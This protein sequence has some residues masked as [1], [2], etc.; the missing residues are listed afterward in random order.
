MR[1]RLN[2]NKMEYITFGSRAHIHKTS[3][4]PLTTS[5]DIIQ[6][7]PHVKYLRG[8]L[9]SELNFNK[10]ITMTLQ[11]AMS[12]FTCRKAIQKYLTKQACVTLVPSLCIMHLDYSNALLYGLPKIHKE[13]KNSS[14]HICQ[15]CTATL[16][17][18]Q[19]NTSTHG[20]SLA[21][22]WTMNPLQYY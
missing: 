4:I 17:V 9:D 12:N 22:N 6:M 11:K 14:K 2:T 5:N 20:P 21:H 10:D 15:A 1:V 19:C 18:L 13:T 8:T 16:K 3:T 7:T